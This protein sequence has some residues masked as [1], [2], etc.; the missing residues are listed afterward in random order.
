MNKNSMVVLT[1]I[2]LF[3]IILGRVAAFTERRVKKIV[4]YSTISQMGLGA[5]VYGLG[6]FYLGYINLIAHGL[7]KRLLFIQIGYLIH[8]NYNQQNNKIWAFGANVE[9]FLHV[10]LACTLFG[11]SGITFFSGILS[12]EAILEGILIGT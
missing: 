6:F 11:L 8:L 10:Q 12:K 1:L 4:A 3:T 5:I 9:G 7:A 2:G